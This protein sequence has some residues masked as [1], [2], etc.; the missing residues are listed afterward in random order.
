MN[1]VLVANECIHSRHRDKLL[2]VICMLDLEKRPMTM[3]SRAS[4]FMC[5]G[6]WAL[7]LNGGYGF[8]DVFRQHLFRCW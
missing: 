4:C 6:G 7:A 3:L 5:F 8:R 1:G 2:G